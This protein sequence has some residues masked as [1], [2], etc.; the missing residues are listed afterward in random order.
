[1]KTKKT[2]TQAQTFPSFVKC[3]RDG[4]KSEIALD[5]SVGRPPPFMSAPA[6]VQDNPRNRLT[7]PERT[8]VYI[9]IYIY[10]C[11]YI[12]I[13]IIMFIPS[14]LIYCEMLNFTKRKCLLERK[15]LFL[16]WWAGL[17]VVGLEQRRQDR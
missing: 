8:D 16:V 11:I 17:F 7:K 1:V 12:Y 9:Q 6:C 10:I 2:N 13:Y 4:H 5:F 14:H 3:K 15:L